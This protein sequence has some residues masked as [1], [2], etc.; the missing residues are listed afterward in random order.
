MDLVDFGATERLVEALVHATGEFRG[1]YWVSFETWRSISS[2]I[3]MS[4]LFCRVTALS[5]LWGD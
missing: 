2:V 5:A 4:A 3:N 1:L